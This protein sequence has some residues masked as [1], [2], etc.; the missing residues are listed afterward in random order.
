LGIY[1]AVVAFTAGLIL[2]LSITLLGYA[3][4]PLF[5]PSGD[6]PTDTA[7]SSST[8]LSS[9]ESDW[10]SVDVLVDEPVAVSH[11]P[12]PTPAPTAAPVSVAAPAPR[13]ASRPAASSCPANYFCYPRLGISGR[14]VPYTDCSGR[15]DVGSSIRAVTCVSDRWLAA[16]AWT[17]FGRITAWR[18]GDVVFAYGARYVVYGAYT[19][20][21]CSA[22]RAIAPLSLQTSLSSAACG[23]VLVV[24]A[25]RG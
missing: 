1:R 24:Q 18:A 19:Q 12:D 21:A 15:T 17:Q 23:P 20:T 14:I 3:T 13:A 7:P 25:R 6:S 11:A 9:T 8:M 16:H 22:A 2:S 10:L 4:A 5:A